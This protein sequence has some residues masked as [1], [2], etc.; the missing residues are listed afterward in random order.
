[1]NELMSHGVYG[2]KN[3]RKI[4]PENNNMIHKSQ[5]YPTQHP[6]TSQVPYLLGPLSISSEENRKVRE[7]WNAGM[8]QGK[9]FVI[10]EIS[11]IP[12]KRKLA[13]VLACALKATCATYSQHWE[14]MYF[15]WTLNDEMERIF[16]VFAVM[17][18][19][20]RYVKNAFA[21]AVLINTGYKGAFMDLLLWRRRPLPPSMM[22]LEHLDMGTFEC[23]LRNAICAVLGGEYGV[24]IIRQSFSKELIAS[25]NKDGYNELK[26][27]VTI[28]GMNPQGKIAT[29]MQIGLKQADDR[30]VFEKRHM[31]LAG[32]KL[33]ERKSERR[34]V[35]FSLDL[36]DSVMDNFF[37]A[38]N[39]QLHEV[40]VDPIVKFITIDGRTPE[41]KEKLDGI[42]HKIQTGLD[43]VPSEIIEAYVDNM[44]DGITKLDFNKYSNLAHLTADLGKKV[45]KPREDPQRMVFVYID[46]EKQRQSRVPIDVVEH[47]IGAAIQAGLNSIHLDGTTDIPEDDDLKYG[48]FC[49]TGPLHSAEVLD[50]YEQTARGWGH[51]FWDILAPELPLTNKMVALVAI[52]AKREQDAII[53]EKQAMDQ[54]KS[55]NDIFWYKTWNH[56]KGKKLDVPN[57]IS[58]SHILNVLPIPGNDLLLKDDDMP[59]QMPAHHPITLKY[60]RNYG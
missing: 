4:A 19:G 42:R 12:G 60:L 2:K 49:L 5:W 32:A 14:G 20:E 21:T 45:L 44:R 11:Q 37:T 22:S 38:M 10:P 26:N 54:R 53:A 28:P 24:N 16:S 59:D 41:G 7:I 58:Y 34:N 35:D 1:M 9:D 6:A 8:Y 48:A 3:G 29:V 57:W 52:S 30:S 15:D 43:R 46:I 40:A 39:Q 33:I 51:G 23:N 18:D 27:L 47:A 56:P 31:D 17:P 13:Q 25:D 55:V 36:P 50:T